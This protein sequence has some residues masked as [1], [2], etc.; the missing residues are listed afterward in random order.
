MTPDERVDNCHKTPTHVIAKRALTPMSGEKRPLY[1][2]PQAEK[3]VSQTLIKAFGSEECGDAAETK[4]Q[5]SN[6]SRY[7]Y[8]CTTCINKKVI[9]EKTHA[10]QDEKE[11]FVKNALEQNEKAKNSLQAETDHEHTKKLSI[12]VQLRAAMKKAEAD[13]AAARKEKVAD[14]SLL[15]E[16]FGVEHGKI[17]ENKR[18][19]VRHIMRGIIQSQLAANTKGNAP[20]STSY[21]TLS[22]S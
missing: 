5:R 15:G 21:S 18:E 17:R 9:S 1:E 22:L 7:G 12:Y 8:T 10:V 16:N 19:E 13:K 14:G 4:S 20:E 6:C 3:P 2:K 11:S